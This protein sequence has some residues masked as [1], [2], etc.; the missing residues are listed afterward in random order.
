SLMDALFGLPMEE[1]LEQI[2][3]IDEVKDALV[4]RTGFFG[5]LL[6]L[7]ESIEQM[8][9]DDF[10]VPTLKELAISSDELVEFEVTA[11][12]WSDSVAKY[13]V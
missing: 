3:V 5:E 2:P 7:A 1:I 13:A 8:D 10:V 9:G 6:K 12:S 4:H 11:F